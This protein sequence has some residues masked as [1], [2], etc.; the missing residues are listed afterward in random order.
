MIL[1]D[2]H[3]KKPTGDAMPSLNEPFVIPKSMPAE[4]QPTSQSS[5][6]SQAPNPAQT[7]ATKRKKSSSYMSVDG[8]HKLSSM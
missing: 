3:F 4:S 5:S 8:V 1:T 2:D 6:Q 7:K